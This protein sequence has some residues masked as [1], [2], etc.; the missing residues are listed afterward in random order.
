M[1][2]ADTIALDAEADS[3]HHY[4]PKVCLIQLTFGGHSY[5]VD[6]LCGLD[7]KG[8]LSALSGRKLI[9]HDAGYDLKMLWHC[10]GFVP[11]QEIFDSMLAS[12]LLGYSNISLVG[13]VNDVLGV[14]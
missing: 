1:A 4:Y 11:C 2:G 7:M 9:I 8:F 14:K 5:I 6:P 12:Q 3:F 13:L 10:W